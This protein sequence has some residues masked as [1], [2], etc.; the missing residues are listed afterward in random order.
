MGHI[1]KEPSDDRCFFCDGK[2]GLMKGIG[3]ALS[4]GGCD[5]SFCRPCL[6]G[7]TA[8]EFWK[9]IAE[10][11]GYTYPLKYVKKPKHAAP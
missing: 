10:N 9:L 11:E 5:Y 3:I 4:M 1:D 2:K 7:M 6:K 8:D